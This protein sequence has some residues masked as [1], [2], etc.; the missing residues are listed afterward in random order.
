[1]YPNYTIVNEDKKAKKASMTLTGYVASYNSDNSFNSA[2]FIEKFNELKA[3]NTHIHIDIVNLYG[4]SITEGIPVYNHIKETAKAGKIKITGKIEGLA[5]SMGSIIAMAIPV[6]DLEMGNMSRIMNHKARGGAYG[7][8]DEVRN[9]ADTIQG[10]EDDMISIL[11]E[12]TG[13]SDEEVRGKWMDGLDHY[14]KSTEAKKLK[15]VGKVST[16]QLKKR[17]PKNFKS[18]EEA[19]N[20]FDTNLVHNYLNTDMDLENQLRKSLN[21]GANDDVVA[22]VEKLNVTASDNADYKTK[23]ETLLQANQ[24]AE[25]KEADAIIGKLKDGNHI[26]DAQVASWK[27]LFKADHANAKG[28]AE[29]MLTA[30]PKGA[31]NEALGKMLDGLKGDGEKAPVAKTYEWY[32]KNDPDALL[33]MKENDNEAFM[34]LFNES[35]KNA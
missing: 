34:K 21:L 24:D 9:G 19:Y 4:G 23:Y 16:S 17:L 25:Q 26:K 30:N 13:L 2:K 1:M 14:I 22:A 29:G 3:N 15:L 28:I 20:F 33:E 12:R 32:E 27:A 5:A 10:Y 6:D 35:V 7:T 8:A 11:A 18:P 31:T